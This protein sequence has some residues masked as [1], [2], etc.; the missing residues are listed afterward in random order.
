MAEKR[1]HL[2][3]QN[4]MERVLKQARTQASASPTPRESLAVPSFVNI[5]RVSSPPSVSTARP[6]AQLPRPQPVLQPFTSTEP[7]DPVLVKQEP[8][9]REIQAAAKASSRPSTPGADEDAPSLAQ[10]LGE[11][12]DFVAGKKDVW[13]LSCDDF[14]FG[15]R[16]TT[17]PNLVDELV[18]GRPKHDDAA[19]IL[20]V[21]NCVFGLCMGFEQ[22]RTAVALNPY[23]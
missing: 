18:S 5:M 19:R 17:F 11:G 1:T 4:E 16:N 7:K 23:N 21:G 13:D 8:G 6:P 2:E 20:K 22:G 10:F 9:L 15:C 14:L 3:K 12:D